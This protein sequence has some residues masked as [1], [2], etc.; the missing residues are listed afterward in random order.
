MQLIDVHCHLHAKNYQ[1]SLPRIIERAERNG[2]I[3][4]ITAATTVGE[5]DRC[6]SLAAQYTS[7]ETALGIHPWYIS[8][9]DLSL[10]QNLTDSSFKNI[11]AIGEIGLD[12]KHS[13]VPFEIQLTVFETQLS[14][15]KELELP[16]VV[17]C[18]GAFNELISCVKKI[19]LAEPGGI[20]H[21]FSGSSELAE[22]L[23]QLGFYFSI[24]G[25]LT[26]AHSPKRYRMLR[27]IYP[28]YFLLET[29]S[30][31]ITPVQKKPLPNEPSFILYNL[32][33]AA[34]ILE[35]PAEEIAHNTT[36]LAKN[37]FSIA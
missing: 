2:I 1:D 7:V 5:W 20:I 12:R 11:I 31:D 33:A 23:H 8:A 34:K 37:I 24:G 36:Q 22:Q 25:I 19:G 21:S 14:I 9:E 29:D 26:Y 27:S 13:S 35:K 30:P 32:Y 18:I 6:L 16:I 17:H 10:L 3:K 15:A 28:D 4:M